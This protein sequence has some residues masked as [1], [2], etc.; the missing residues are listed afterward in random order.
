MRR[1][2]ER[3]ALVAL[4][5]VA[6]CQG[7]G[8]AVPRP[9]V[10][11]A[12]AFAFALLGDNPYNE[13]NLVKYRRLI[14]HVNARRDLAWVMHV[15]DF[16][17]GQSCSDAE[18]ES[19]FQLN[20]QFRHP[21]ILTPG[22]ND[23]YDCVRERMGG[24]N[25]FERLGA[26]RRIFYPQPGRT[27]GA[28]AF[29]VRTQSAG[30]AFPEFV[31]NVMWQRDGVVF[32]AVHV[33]G[34]TRPPT[35]ESAFERLG[36]AWESWIGEAFDEA[37]RTGAKGLFLAMQAD[38]WLF[39][40][41]PELITRYCPDCPRARPGLEALYPLL[42]RRSREFGGAV[43]VAVGDTHIFRVDK[44]LYDAT[45]ILVENLT[46][47]EPFGHPYVHWVRVEVRP[48]DPA[49]FSFHQELVPDNL[50]NVVVDE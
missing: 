27:T 10:G 34:P 15:G 40:G 2:L 21:L 29:A 38:P 26:L 22:D 39:S 14:E 4:L 5:A 11:S 30:T 28:A 32:A 8:S 17:G 35:D 16:K 33:I 19:R 13:A 23:W 41:L 48:D 25:D 3:L 50:G 37:G 31:E 47:V 36:L 6:G 24:W 42:T 49:V 12:P 1:T 18:L 20:Q 9:A 44:P 46:R 7:G 45:G 43:V